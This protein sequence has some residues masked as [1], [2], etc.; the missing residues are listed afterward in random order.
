LLSENVAPVAA[1][2][3]AWLI[4]FALAAASHIIYWRRKTSA[5][6]LIN[7]LREA[8]F[9]R[10]D[11]FFLINAIVDDVLVIAGLLA[12]AQQSWR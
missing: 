3:A 9:I 8:G 10:D 4:L 6:R 11:S 12:F 7:M 5:R 1:L 2:I